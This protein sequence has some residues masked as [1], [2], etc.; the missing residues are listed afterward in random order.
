MMSGALER[1]SP[2]EMGTRKNAAAVVVARPGPE[3]AKAG[4][5]RG[6]ELVGVSKEYRGGRTS[7]RAISDISLSIADG[8]IVAVIGRSGCGKSTLLRLMS[9]LLLPTE[10]SVRLDGAAVEG[11]PPELRYVFQDYGESLFPWATVQRNVEFGARC[12]PPSAEHPTQIALRNLALVGLADVGQRYPWELSG[13]MQQRV[14]IARAVASSPRWLLM[15]EPFGAVDALSRAGLQDMIQRIRRELQLT[16]VFVT[17]DIEEAVYLADR[18]IV[19]E[20]TGGGIL[21]DVSIELAGTRTQVA[22]RES[23]TFL[24]YRRQLLEL[25]I[26]PSEAKA[27]GR[28]APS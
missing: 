22:T 25:V 8:S 6:L 17:H 20:P 28:S 1:L 23:T 21:K 27:H 4:P 7:V 14:A 24:H 18:V 11:A 10:G 2:S 12:A 15:D 19:L 5:W 9:G 26:G 13:G 3:R 16:I